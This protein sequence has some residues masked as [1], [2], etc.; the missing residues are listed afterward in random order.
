MKTT[1]VIMALL[2]MLFFAIRK[3]DH[4]ASASSRSHLNVPIILTS[5]GQELDT[6]FKDITRAWSSYM[7]AK[8]A[9]EMFKQSPRQ[10]QSGEQN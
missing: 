6:S 10:A 9:A 3:A 8:Q 4:K 2:C 7:M 5:R 1:L